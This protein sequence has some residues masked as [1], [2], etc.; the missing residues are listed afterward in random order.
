[1]DSLKCIDTTGSRS[2]QEIYKYSEWF[3][4]YHWYTGDGYIELPGQY[5]GD[6]E[7]NIEKHIK[8]IRFNQTVQVFPSLR[9]PFK[10]SLLGS[11][12]KT[13]SFLVKYGE[14]LRQ[15]ERIQQLQNLMSNQLKADKNC[16]H[17]KL[18]LRTYQVFPMD[19]MFGLLSWIENSQSIQQIINQNLSGEKT[20]I[21]NDFNKFFINDGKPGFADYGEAALART[22]DDV[23]TM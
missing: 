4:Q 21:I 1:M 11:D 3:R 15:D 2:K 19:T 14:D 5:R 12:G 16:C 8:I 18:F 10:I 6:S 9:K 23:C 7:P 13:Y 22:L 17:H 20:K